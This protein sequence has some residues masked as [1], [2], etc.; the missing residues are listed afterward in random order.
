MPARTIAV[1]CPDWPVTAAAVTGRVAAD[2]PIAV[3]SAHRLVAC[4]AAARASGVRRGLRKREAQAR[5]S[6]LVVLDEDLDRDARVFEPVVCAVEALAPGVE[7][8][9]PGLIVVAARGPTAYFGRETAVAARIIDQVAAETKV[10]C[11]VGIAEGIFAATLAAQ[12]GVVVDPGQTPAFLAPLRVVELLQL[13]GSA[14]AM[15]TREE[16]VGLLRRLGLGTLGAFAALSPRDVA[17][18]F[19]PD[20]VLAHR[21]ARGYDERPLAKRQLPVDLTVVQRF[22]PPVERADAAAFAAQEPASRLHEQLADRGLAC[23][24]LEVQ[25]ETEDGD[26]LVRIWRCAEPL[27][28]RGIADRVRWQLDS[29]VAQRRDAPGGGIVLLRLSPVEVVTS[30]MQRSLWGDTGEVDERASRVLVR[31]QGMLGPDSVFT[32]VLGGGRDPARRVQLIPWGDER[33][34]DLPADPPWPGRLPAPS[35]ATVPVLP[36]PVLSKPVVPKPVVSVAQTEEEDAPGAGGVVDGEPMHSG[37]V[38]VGK[39]EGLELDVVEGPAGL[40][41][42]TDRGA[43]EPED[44]QEPTPPLVMVLD[45]AGKAVGVTGRAVLTAPPHRVAVDGHPPRIVLGWAGPWPVEERWWEPDGGRRR[46]RLQVALDGPAAG[47]A[48]PALLLACENG[49]WRIE[50][51]YD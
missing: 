27:T 10:E 51:V 16:L 42:G 33:V 46:A 7:V 32:A 37:A 43:A 47:S 12:R 36:K 6:D 15:K 8:V 20:A 48:S 5:C 41:S 40:A 3:F 44:A 24:R 50:G 22:D 34:P 9:R 4:S 38:D 49:R 29:W 17:S 14:A 2:R 11:Q 45:A 25:A 1:W 35:P 26:P 31:V 13:T 28:P 30:G 23:T 39:A 18:R 21:L 19:G